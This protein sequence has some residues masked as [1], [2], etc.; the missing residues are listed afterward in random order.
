[1]PWSTAVGWWEPA[2][3]W[4][5]MEMN[6]PQEQAKEHKIPQWVRMTFNWVPLITKVIQQGKRK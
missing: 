2:F 5:E 4:A 3:M 6:G 1:M